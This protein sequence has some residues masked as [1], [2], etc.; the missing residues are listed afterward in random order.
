VKIIW[1]I[2]V[3]YTSTEIDWD[4]TRAKEKEIHDQTGEWPGVF[5]CTVRVPCIRVHEELSFS[6]CDICGENINPGRHQRGI[7]TCSPSCNKIKNERWAAAKEKED[8]ELVGQRPA[9]FWFRIRREC[10]ERDGYL[11]QALL[12][13]GTK[14]GK[15]IRA[16]DDPPGEA[17]HI[18]PISKGG[19]NKL[20][21]LK[22]LCYAHHK[23]E[24][25]RVGAAKRKHKSLVSFGVL[26]A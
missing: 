26:N 17:H 9:F 4:A 19:S 20:E 2:N 23:E 3:P 14:C 21:N 1:G 7:T 10:F 24:H 25:S 15:D 8:R 16:G 12:P 13:D 6:V 5:S 18:V 11:C 22:T